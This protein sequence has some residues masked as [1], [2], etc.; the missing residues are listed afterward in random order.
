MDDDT[1]V[2]AVLSD[3]RDKMAKAVSHTQQDF[4]GVRTG[5][6]S[7]GLVENLRIDYYGSETPLKQ[8]AGINAFHRSLQFLV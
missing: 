5:R 8:L 3:S 4:S 6:A 7:P 2:G 1:F